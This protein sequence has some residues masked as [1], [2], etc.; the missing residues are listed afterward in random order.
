MKLKDAVRRRDKLARSIE[1]PNAIRVEEVSTVKTPG[2][3]GSEEAW[4]QYSNDSRH[5]S[6]GTIIRRAAQCLSAGPFV[7]RDSRQRWCE[8]ERNL[9]F[10]RRLGVLR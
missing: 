9:W 10:A 5:V 8:Q 1:T 2:K 4:R 7:H 6:R 3:R